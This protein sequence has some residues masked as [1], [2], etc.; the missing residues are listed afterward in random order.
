MSCGVAVNT[1]TKTHYYRPHRSMSNIKIIIR[2]S[3]QIKYIQDHPVE[4]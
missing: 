1:Y 4:F 2:I 3:I